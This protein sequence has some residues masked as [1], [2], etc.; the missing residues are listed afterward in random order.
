MHIYLWTA[1]RIGD[2]R[3]EDFRIGDLGWLVVGYVLRVAGGIKIVSRE[4]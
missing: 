4:G 1:L 2:L 3:M